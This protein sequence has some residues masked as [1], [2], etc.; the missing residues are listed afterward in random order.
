MFQLIYD[1]FV[2]LTNNYSQLPKSFQERFPET[3]LVRA[4]L[5]AGVF[6]ENLKDFEDYE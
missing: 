6:V 5:S 1:V 2:W 4:R 3:W